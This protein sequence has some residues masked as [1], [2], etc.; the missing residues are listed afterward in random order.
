MRAGDIARLGRLLN[1]SHKSLSELYETMG[2][3]PDALAAAAQRHPAC[4]GSRL[5]GGGFGGC[6]VSLVRADS[7]ARFCEDVCEEYRQK[8]GLSAKAY[9]AEI[10]DGITV[11]A[12]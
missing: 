10:D 7:V 5:T 8:T 2:A 4:A 11:R 12:L 1:A 9:A 3:E 6:T